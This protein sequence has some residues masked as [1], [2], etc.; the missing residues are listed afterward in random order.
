MTQPEKSLRARAMA[1]VARRET[2]RLQL[3]RKLAP[4]A[5]SEDE[6]ENVLDEFAAKNWQSDERYT[7]AFIHSRYGKYGSL[8]LKHALQANGIATEVIADKLPDTESELANAVAVL[9]KKFGEP[10][11]NIKDKQ[12][13]IRFLLYRGF[14]MET[15][16][17]ALKT[18]WD[19]WENHDI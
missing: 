15:A 16:C 3:K 13:Q 18:N 14:T 4:Y 5:E 9:H 19:E 10:A 11:Q 7:E 8:R 6:L 12:K 1:I 2:S 17:K